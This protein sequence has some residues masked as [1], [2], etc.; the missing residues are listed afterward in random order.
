MQAYLEQLEEAEMLLRCALAVSW[1]RV[2]LVI[3]LKGDIPVVRA[4]DI[5][6][7]AHL[8][9]INIF[10]ELHTCI[11]KIRFRSVCQNVRI[12]HTLVHTFVQWVK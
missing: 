12:L 9:L 4:G 8:C 2:L 7:A 5:Y 10:I 11:Y 3:A 1:C 6:R